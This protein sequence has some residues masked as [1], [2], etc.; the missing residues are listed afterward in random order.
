MAEAAF[1]ILLTAIIQIRERLE[2]ARRLLKQSK[3][4]DYYKVL[5]VSR[6]ADQR[7]VKKAL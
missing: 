3:R 5:D 2:K 4:K 7:T 6:D 1:C